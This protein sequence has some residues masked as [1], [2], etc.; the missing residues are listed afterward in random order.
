MQDF[1]I[2]FV[3]LLWR[4][5]IMFAELKKKKEVIACKI[6]FIA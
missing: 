1:C 4:E 3:E 2:A 5:R 6:L